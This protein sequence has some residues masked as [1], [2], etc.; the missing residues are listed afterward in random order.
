MFCLT[1]MPSYF[2]AYR[3][4]SGQK[5]H[6]DP[7]SYSWCLMRFAIL[8]AVLSNLRTFLPQVGIEITGGIILYFLLFFVNQPKDFIFILNFKFDN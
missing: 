4:L 6:S 8:R 2:F 7:S 5:E 3:L 1:L